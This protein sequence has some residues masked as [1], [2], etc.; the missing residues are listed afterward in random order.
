MPGSMTSR[1]RMIAYATGKP[2]D[3]IPFINQW[4]PWEETVRR[5]RQQGMKG[6]DE[7]YTK[8]GYDSGGI[9]AGVDF[10]MCPR[11]ERQTIDQDDEHIT[12]RDEHGVL[13]RARQDGT[14]MSE[15]LDYPVKDRKT[16]EE[17]KWRF[18]PDTAER[19]PADWTQRARELKNSDEMVHVCFYPYGFLAG[20]RTMMGAETC[21]IKMASEPDLIDDI[22]ETLCNLWCALLARMFEETRVDAIYAWEDMAGKNGSLISPAMFRRFLTPYYR[23][24]MDL[25]DRHGVK[26]RMV[27]SDGLMHELTPLFLEAGL[28]CVFPYEVQAGNDLPY[29]FSQNPDL[30]ALGH[31]DKRAPVHGTAA[32]DAEIERIKS[33]LPLGRY[34][35]HMDHGVPP[36]VPWDNYQR[37]VWRWK[38]LTGKKD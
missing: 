9:D 27:D 15:W 26:L 4:G 30:C 29:L 22:N 18:D 13:Q 8:F 11:F 17:H 2:V 14:S 35:P 28:T 24:I 36:D 38:E 7:W 33:I 3:R 25:A 37:L 32:V 1:E 20:A 10:E 23:R 16:W 31:I 6:D 19:F 12:F 34:I 5:W 21:L